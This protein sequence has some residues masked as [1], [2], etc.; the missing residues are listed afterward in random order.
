MLI[1]TI[2]TF[3]KKFDDTQ[4][5]TVLIMSVILNKNKL[6]EILIKKNFKIVC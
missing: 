6:A 1:A 4:V 3:T 5:Y 2:L